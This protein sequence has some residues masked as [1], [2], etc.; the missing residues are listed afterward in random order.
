MRETLSFFFFFFNDP[1]PTEIYPLSLPDALPIY[2]V[3][4]PRHHGGDGRGEY[5]CC[6]AHREGEENV[7]RV[8]GVL[9][10]V[11]ETH[12]RHDRRQREGESQAVL[13]IGRAH[14]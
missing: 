13:Q 2:R 9:E 4:P 5:A 10:R 7:D 6:D 11:A 12:G 14:A 8:L 3:E 1:P